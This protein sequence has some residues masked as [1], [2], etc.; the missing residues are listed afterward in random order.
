[1]NYKIDI[2]SLQQNLKPNMS[3]HGWGKCDFR[4]PMKCF[5]GG[6]SYMSKMPT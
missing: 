3:W 2:F 6:V 5:Y 4:S 1:M